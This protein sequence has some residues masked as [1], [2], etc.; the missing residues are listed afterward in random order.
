ML[1]EGFLGPV[2]K[3]F[4]AVVILATARKVESNFAPGDEL[5]EKLFDRRAHS[6]PALAAAVGT[7][8]KLCLRPFFARHEIV[9]YLMRGNMTVMQIRRKAAGCLLI[10]I[11]PQLAVSGNLLGEKPAPFLASGR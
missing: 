8:R 6:P 3:R 10:G 11:V 2:R 1:F 5:I 4:V 7:V 9:K